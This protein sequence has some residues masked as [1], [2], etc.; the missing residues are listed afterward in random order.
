MPRRK[1][2]GLLTPPR[3]SQQIIENTQVVESCL[4]DLGL[5]YRK[6]RKINSLRVAKSAEGVQGT[7]FLHLLFSSG[8]RPRFEDRTKA[9]DSVSARTTRTRPGKLQK[10]EMK[11]EFPVDRS[12]REEMSTREA[13][14]EVVE[15][16]FV[17]QID[18]R[19]LGA[20]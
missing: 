19:E 14:K 7:A 2:S 17:H 20:E 5:D 3:S 18:D 11:S 10:L 1:K 15:G 4:R 9:A 8:P 12:W 16:H 13:G 6:F